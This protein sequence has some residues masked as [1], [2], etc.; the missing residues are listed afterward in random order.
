MDHLSENVRRLRI[1]L[2]LTQQGL[3]A[4]AKCSKSLV[5]KV[6]YGHTNVTMRQLSGLAGALGVE[7]DVLLA[8]HAGPPPPA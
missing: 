3:A 6:E 1:A 4:V 8:E 7:V 2:G 5:E